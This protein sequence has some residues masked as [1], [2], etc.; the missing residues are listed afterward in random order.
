MKH[1]KC[2]FEFID[3]LFSFD[4]LPLIHEFMSISCFDDVTDP[5][6]KYKMCLLV[7]QKGNYTRS[8]PAT[9]FLLALIATNFS[10][11]LLLALITE[12]CL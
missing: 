3:T 1:S 11:E 10:K 9:D 8:K 12:F 7:V 2:S 5:I 4:G 6:L